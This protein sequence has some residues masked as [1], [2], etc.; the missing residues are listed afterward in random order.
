M[1][2]QLQVQNTISDNMVHGP[3]VSD[4]KHKSAYLLKQTG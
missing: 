4:A 2:K 1:F 3:A